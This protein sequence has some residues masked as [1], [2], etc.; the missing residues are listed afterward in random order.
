MYLSDSLK[1]FNGRGRSHISATT[2]VDDE[3]AYLTFS[4]APGVKDFLPLARFK[5]N[6]FC[7]KVSSNHQ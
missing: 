5:G 6:L 1:L 4:S 7:M 3:F 2:S